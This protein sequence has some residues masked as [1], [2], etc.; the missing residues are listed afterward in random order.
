MVGESACST[1]ATT[2]HEFQVQ[3]KMDRRL[4]INWIRVSIW[5][6]RP[7]LDYIHQFLAEV[8]VG[9]KAIPLVL[10]IKWPQCPVIMVDN[11]GCRENL[12]ALLPGNSVERNM[13]V[14][15]FD[16]HSASIGSDFLIQV[17]VLQS[18]SMQINKYE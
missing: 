4:K 12:C 9:S 1:I 3:V 13:S 10:S 14:V 17:I 16:V 18:V 15:V 2:M 5:G 6:K 7:N 11:N 8:Q